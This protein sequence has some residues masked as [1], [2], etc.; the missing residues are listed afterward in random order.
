LI[1]DIEN[2]EKWE[3]ILSLWVLYGLCGYDTN[4]VRYGR[5]ARMWN[6]RDL[7]SVRSVNHEIGAGID[8]PFSI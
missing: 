7:A 3:R 5:G 6:G 2:T 1:K 4:P 8:F